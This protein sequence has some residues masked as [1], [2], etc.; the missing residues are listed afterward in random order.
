MN[1]WLPTRQNWWTPE[2]AP[3]VRVVLDDHVAGERGAVAEDRLVADMAVVRHVRV[4]H[5]Q[6]VIADARQP[7]AAGRAAMNRRELADDVAVADHQA[8][9]LAAELEILRNQPD[10]G[11]REDLV[12]V[13][14][15]GPAVDHR[16]RADAAVAADRDVGADRGVRPDAGAA[17]DLRVRM[18]DGRRMDRDP[19]ASAG[20]RPSTGPAAAP[21]RR[22]CGRRDRRC[23]RRARDSSAAIRGALPGAADRQAPP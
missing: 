18:D 4:G 10:R 11:H 23:R 9:P 8:R 7:A 3:D 22:R 5:E 19:G 13:A 2:K 20:R 14:D 17:A 16:R 1:A 21:P 15:L 12:G 6:V